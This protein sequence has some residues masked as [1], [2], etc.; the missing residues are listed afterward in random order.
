M[1]GEKCCERCG[2]VEWIENA[3]EKDDWQ[4]D[5]VFQTISE[6]GDAWVKKANESITPS[7]KSL[8]FNFRAPFDV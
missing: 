1:G 4:K 8:I 2:T 6:P 3:G 7:T 5:Q